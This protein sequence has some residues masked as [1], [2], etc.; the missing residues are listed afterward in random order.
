M[1]T[2]V[3]VCFAITVAI[4]G[5]ITRV[6][7]LFMSK[8]ILLSTFLQIAMKRVKKKREKIRQ[9]F[10][11]YFLCFVYFMKQIVRHFMIGHWRIFGEFTD[12]A[13]SLT[14]LLSP[15]KKMEISLKCS[16]NVGMCFIIYACVLHD[17]SFFFSIFKFTYTVKPLNSGNL[18]SEEFV[19]YSEAS[20]IQR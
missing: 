8:T 4:A 20:V 13:T 7:K 9:F 15:N 2:Q 17:F 6:Q 14:N 19:P 10:V 18:E 11:F 3:G 12:P 5:I 16:R 1:A